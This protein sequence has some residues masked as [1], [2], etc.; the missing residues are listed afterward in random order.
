MF[1][2]LM[3]AAALNFLTGNALVGLSCVVTAYVF[4]D[5]ED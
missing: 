2:F 5:D 1:G 4:C 3:F